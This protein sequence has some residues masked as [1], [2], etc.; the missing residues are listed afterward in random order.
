MYSALGNHQKAC[1]DDIGR[2]GGARAVNQP[3]S[4]GRLLQVLLRFWVLILV[5]TLVAAAAAYGATRLMTTTYTA[6]AT[7]L[8]KALPGTGVTANYEAA[9]F[10]V[11]RAKSYPSFIYSSEVLEGVRSDLGDVESAED[12]R[13]DLTA[14]NPVDTPLVQI[15][16]TGRT[17]TDAQAKA[18]SAARHLAR[19]VSQIETI[20]GKS[21]VVME[22]AVQAGLPR[23][24][25][26]PQVPLLVAVG[27]FT[28]F[29][30]AVL[31][32]LLLSYRSTRRRGRSAKP[33]AAADAWH[34]VEGDAPRAS[35]VLGPGEQRPADATSS[36]DGVRPDPDSGTEHARDEAPINGVPTPELQTRALSR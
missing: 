24:P 17:P 35:A 11:A 19:F 36:V 9:Q 15:S 34:G 22:T 31:L 12:L 13:L 29:A 6:T 26:S 7:Q 8:V 2:F 5:L 1:D 23:S 10:A 27:G 3:L 14:T 20:D 25:T 28:G 21:P 16:A 30:F 33:V 32:A 4:L 18:D